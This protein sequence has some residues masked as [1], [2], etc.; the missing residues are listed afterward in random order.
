MIIS[1]KLYYNTKE[2]I[3]DFLNKNP[4]K[5]YT[6]AL[7]ETFPK[8]NKNTINQYLMVWRKAQ[9]NTMKDYIEPIRD[10]LYVLAYKSEPTQKLSNKELKSMAMLNELVEAWGK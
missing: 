9:E 10:M 2:K 1:K 5:A 8:V 3:M 6:K 7:Y 4:K